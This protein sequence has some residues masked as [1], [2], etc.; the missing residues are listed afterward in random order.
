MDITSQLVGMNVRLS[1]YRVGEHTTTCPQCSHTRTKKQDK[2]LSVKIDEAGF[3]M[4]CHHCGWKGGKVESPS[5]ILQRPAK[6]YVKP[7]FEVKGLNQKHLD[8]LM[9]ERHIPAEII[10]MYDITSVGEEIAFPL[11]KNGEVVNVK[12]RGPQKKFR[13]E[14]NA[15]KVFFGMQCCASG[16]TLVIVEGEID[17]FSVKAAGYDSVVSVPEGAP[18][19][20][21]EETPKPEEDRKFA[22]VW[23]CR[24]FLERYNHIIIATDNDAAGNVLAEEL[25][26]RIGRA[27]CSRATFSAKDANAEHVENGLNAVLRGLRAAVDYPIEGLF[28]VSDCAADIFDMWSGERQ[29]RGKST[30][31]LKID[32]L[33]TIVEGQLTVVTGVPSSGKSQFV[34]EVMINLAKQYGMKFAVCS[35]END[36]REHIFKYVHTYT[37]LFPRKGVMHE[38]QLHEALEFLHEHF[39]F[40]RPDDTLPT[41]DWILQKAKEAVLRHGI[42][43][44]VIDPYNEIAQERKRGDSETDFISEMLGKMKRFLQSYS[45]HGWIVAHPSKPDMSKDKPK[46]PGLYDISGSA[47]WANKAD[48]GLVVHRE[49][50]EDGTR[51]N[52][53]TVHVTKVRQHWVGEVGR[54]KMAFDLKTRRYF[55]AD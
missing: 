46:A 4:F 12:Y 11:Y 5:M 27:K 14:A 35:F 16:G 28:R 48:I 3:T 33:M 19:K 38:R 20:L 8:Y 39:F 21:T 53:A 26:R 43:G 36:M 7:K 40:I 18:A 15:E 37:G 51:S 1:N 41:I 24:E 42:N 54:Q 55:E 31:W 25:A 49:F 2:C 47:H 23:N 52:V 13:Q 22:F 44:L 9:K 6:E 50:E 45:V 17:A 32:R 29:M 34:D 10:G 30:G